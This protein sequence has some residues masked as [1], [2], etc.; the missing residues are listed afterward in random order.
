MPEYAARHLVRP[1]LAGLAQVADSYNISPEEKLAW[2]LVYI[3]RVNLWLD[4]KLAVS[5]FLLVFVLR[6]RPGIDAEKT[7]RRILNVQKPALETSI[8][9]LE[10]H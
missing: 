1:G 8:K 9:T 2:D 4:F 6:W 5:A 3:D 7:I 10:T